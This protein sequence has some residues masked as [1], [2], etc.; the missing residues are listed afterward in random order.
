MTAPQR[1]TLPRWVRRW[2]PRPNPRQDIHQNSLFAV[3][4][5]LQSRGSTKQSR[6]LAGSRGEL[7][8]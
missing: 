8:P 6:I 7:Q 2:L 5:R 4:Y 1:R 3:H